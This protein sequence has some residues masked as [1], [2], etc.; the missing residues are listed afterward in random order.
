M[1]KILTESR[2]L[3]NNKIKSYNEKINSILEN[4]K[5]TLALI[6][7]DSFDAPYKKITLCEEMISLSMFY[8]TINN[9]SVEFLAAKNGDSLNEAR[10]NIYK[11]IIYLEGIVTNSISCQ[12]SEIEDK[13]ASIE[14]LS[15]EKR[16]YLIRKL[17]LAIR[18]VIDAFGDNT[19]WRWSF[20]ELQGRY[21]TVVKNLINMKKAC[22]DYFDPSSAD[23]ETTVTYVRL[24]LK[25]LEQSASQYR[26]KYE[27]S[28][29]R[30]DDMRFA[31][32]YLLAKRK[33]C[34]LINMRDEAEEIKKKVVVWKEKLE[35][36]H[37]AGL[38]N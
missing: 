34:L 2:E 10:K 13:V 20:V 22:Q 21:A 36:D 6:Q 17:G 4:E 16:S 24:I 33:I 31:I 9:L 15:I 29:R 8:I 5:N 26:D 18:L 12:Y 3:F 28:T 1:A 37:K 14:N 35:A 23:Y 25:L 19:K 30:L 27:L 38:A 7:K 32:N 11:A